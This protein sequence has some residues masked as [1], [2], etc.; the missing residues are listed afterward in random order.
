VTF[1]YGVAESEV[2]TTLLEALLAEQRG[3]R[4]VEV[5]NF[6]V[7]GYNPYNEVALFE[8]IGAA[9]QPDLVLVQFCINDLNDP[10]LHFDA[11]TLRL[12]ELPD[13]AFPDPS[14]RALPMPGR[15]PLA[16]CAGR[17]RLCDL[18]QHALFEGRADRNA[19]ARTVTPRS[20]LGA[21]ERVW[22]RALYGRLAQWAAVHGAGFVVVVFPHLKQ[23]ADAS[24]D[25]IGRD[26]ADVGREDGWLAIDLLPAFRAAAEQRA[27][28][29]FLDL[30][31]PNSAG[32]HV[33][34][35]ALGRELLRLGLVP[36]SQPSS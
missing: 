6:G 5:L 13:A 2:Y 4:E 19:L 32:H 20:A 24:R 15:S 25:G 26:I 35:Q 1:G 10:R 33:A 30:W 18:L 3:E 23:L 11:H 14:V 29:L 12:L 17:A 27:G 8:G 28:P 7:G 22:L 21:V 34:A 16:F 9:Y 31:H 36:G